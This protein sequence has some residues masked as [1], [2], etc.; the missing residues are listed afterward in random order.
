MKSCIKETRLVH[1]G[2]FAFFYIKYSEYFAQRW[3]G[4]PS[5]FQRLKAHAASFEKVSSTVVCKLGGTLKLIKSWSFLIKEAHLV[6]NGPFVIFLYKIFG[7]FRSTVACTVVDISTAKGPNSQL[8]RSLQYSRL[9]AGRH[10]NTNSV[11]VILDK[12]SPPRSEWP[13]CLFSI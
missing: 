5:T 12:R 7:A 8:R 10:A 9:Q 6:Q 4:Q 1:N 2:T 3:R 13:I 11:V